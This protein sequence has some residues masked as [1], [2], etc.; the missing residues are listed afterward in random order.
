MHALSVLLGDVV[1]RTS[2]SHRVE[3]LML[4][5]LVVA[6]ATSSLEWAD[7]FIEIYTIAVGQRPKAT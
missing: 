4:A 2:K 1:E 7:S 3:M 5:F 6:F